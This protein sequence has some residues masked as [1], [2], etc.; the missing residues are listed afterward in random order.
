MKDWY[1][2]IA[3]NQ[4]VP[5]FYNMLAQGLV[6]NPVFSFYL[7]RDPNAQ[8]GGEILL[9]GSDPKYFSGNFTYV[10]VTR[11]GYWQFKMDGVK[12]GDGTFCKAGCQ[13]IADTGTSLI[14]GPLDEVTAINKALGG[15]PVVGG[16]YVIGEALRFR[17]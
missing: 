17:V 2:T 13:A 7:N 16:E 1:N 9:G 6:N 11:K 3:V 14:A 12:V 10:P 15:T 8:P 5:P 4:V